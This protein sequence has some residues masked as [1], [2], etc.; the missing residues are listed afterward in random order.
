MKKNLNV[1]PQKE[2]VGRECFNMGSKFIFG[3]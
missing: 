1:Y 3:L 2:G